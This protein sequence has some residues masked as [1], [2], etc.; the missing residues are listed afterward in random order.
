M[1]KDTILSEDRK[2]HYILSCTWDETKTTILF[3]LS[4]STTDENED[5]STSQKVGLG[6]LIMT[7][8]FAF[9]TTN[10]QG[11]YSEKN[12]VGSENDYYLKKNSQTNQ[13]RLSLA[14]G[15]HGSFNNRS[16]KVY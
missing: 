1:I 13:R 5:M 11:L 9:I 7:N 8:L 14:E 3:I 4:P 16:Q 2:Y 15:N 6:G 12:H 10:P